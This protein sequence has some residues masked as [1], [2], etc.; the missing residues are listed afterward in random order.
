M[1]KFLINFTIIISSISGVLICILPKNSVADGYQLLWIHP[2]T[3][4]IV[5]ILIFSNLIRYKKFKITVYF[6][7]LLSWIRC[8][9]IPIVSSL[10]G[11]YNGISYMKTFTGSI[12]L[13]IW[14]VPYELIITSFFLWIMVLSNKVPLKPN[15]ELKLKGN[16][17]IYLIFIFIALSLYL[18]IG[19]NLN[20][21]KLFFISTE[22]TEA[23]VDIT[24]TP[25]LLLRYIIKS[26]VIFFF[27][28][29]VSYCKNRYES[30]GKKRYV[31]YAIIVG[32]IN[33]G[34][35]IGGRR[36][37]QLYT[38]LVV[39]FILTRAFKK[40]RKRIITYIVIT[41][42][43]VAFVMTIYK[44]FSVAYYGSYTAAL[45]ANNVNLEFISKNLQ[46]YFFG[47]QNLAVTI[48]LKKVTDLNIMNMFYDFGRSIFGVSFLLKNKMM[49]T[50]EY[51]N[52]F[53]YGVSKANGHVISG[54]GYGYI[55][56]GALFSPIIACLNIFISIKL[57]KYFNKTNSYEMTY[58]VGYI[59]IRF[60]TNIYA[61]TPPLISLSTIM[62]FT[63]GLIY[64]VAKLFKNNSNRI[65]LTIRDE[66][67]KCIKTIGGFNK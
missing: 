32:I 33:V 21:I 51:F 34:I 14:L 38:C 65:T 50:T 52:T 13:A 8:V 54:L 1:R 7:I 6:T 66:C 15:D 57:E 64:F 43:S 45:N 24:S 58:I 59:L 47:T 23:F 9:L 30:K 40:Y 17:Y 35:I 55:Y 41:A 31:Y 61:N 2:L 19:R 10:S 48:E 67:S 28:W 37:E 25:I 12:E 39:I 42:I 44:Q 56:F 5:F 46:A 62:L 3:F 63:A 27:V 22:K 29:S 36:S 60:V 11:V 49:M 18:L 4:L 16:K 26:G 20:I 53:I